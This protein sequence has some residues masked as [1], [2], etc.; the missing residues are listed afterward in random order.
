MKYQ[1]HLQTPIYRHSKTF[2]IVLFFLLSLKVISQNIAHQKN[3]YKI[4]LP[5]QLLIDSDRDGIIDINDLDDD[6]DGILD[7]VEE[8]QCRDS[9]SGEIIG[10]NL[11]LNPGFELGNI[12][13]TT[14]LLYF[15]DCT[16]NTNNQGPFYYA[17]TTEA[18]NCH[19]RWT[20]PP[21]EG[22]RFCAIDFPNNSSQNLWC[23]SLP[24]DQNKAYVFSA[25]FIN[26]LQDI[27]F[28]RTPIFGFTVTDDNSGTVTDFGQSD[29]QIDLSL[30]SNGWQEAGFT[31]TT[32]PEATTITICLKNITLGVGGNDAGIDNITLKTTYCDSDN[33]GIPNK[34]DLDSDNDGIYD[35]IEAGN[36][37]IIDTN[38]DG[39]ADGSV[40]AN[41]VPISTPNGTTPINSDN[42]ESPDYI[43]I[44]AD[45]D[46]IQDNIEAQ[47]TLSYIAPNEADTN[48]NGVDDAYDA[49]PIIPINT[50]GD[51]EPDYL[52]LN[53]DNDCLGDNV[54]AYDTNGDE[55]ADIIASGT[56][57]DNDGLDDA[58]DSVVL[59]VNTSTTN[60]TDNYETPNN[61]PNNQPQGGEVN[62]REYFNPS[63]PGTDGSLTLCNTN[64]PVDL[65]NSL[66]GTPDANG[67][68]TP[69]L[70]SGTGI[71]DPKADLDGT[72]TY[73]ISKN[74]CPDVSAQ[75]VVTINSAPNAGINSTIELCETDNT[76]NLIDKLGGTPTAGGI[77][78]PA[79]NSGTGIFNPSLDA[80]GEYT[81][82][83]IGTQP[84]NDDSANILVNVNPLPNAG[85]NSILNLCKTDDT[86]NLFNSLEGSPDTGGVW[87]PLLNST[88][89]IFDPALDASGVYTY[90]VTGTSPCSDASTEIT[91]NI[92]T[93]PNAGLN[94]FIS[95][96]NNDSAINLFNKI[97]GTPDIG[98]TW[99]PTL[100][101]GS[102]IFDPAI[103][104]P[105]IYSYT[106]NDAYCLPSTSQ[107]T[108]TINTASNAGNDGNLSICKTNEPVDLFTILNTTTI[109]GTWTPTLTSGSSIF[110]PNTD[111]AGTYTYTVNGTEP[112]DNDSAEITI[113]IYDELLLI[114]PENLRSCDTNNDNI[115]A[116]DLEEQT[117]IITADNVNYTV[118]YHSNQTDAD[119][120]QAP[121]TSPYT[122][123]TNP[124]TI[125]SRV[126]NSN[127][128]CYNSTINFNIE[129]HDEVI[130]NNDVYE[131][132]D[133][134]IE[135]D[136]NTTNN[137]DL[138]SRNEFILGPN[139]VSSNFNVS[140]YLTLDN[141]HNQT[142]PLAT[143]YT[144]TTNVQTIY[145]RVENTTTGCYKTSEVL[146]K[147]NPLP[148]FSLKEIYSFC[149]DNNGEIISPLP[150]INTGLNNNS[151]TFKWY[152]N[153]IL[154]SEETDSIL[155]PTQ[156]GIYSV[157]VTQNNTGC[158]YKTQTEVIEANSPTIEIQQTSITFVEQNNILAV[159]TNNGNPDSLY[160]FSLDNGPWVNNNNNN[161]YIF[162]N[163]IAGEHT[164]TVKDINGCGEASASIILLDF[165]PYFTPNGDGF[166]D[167]WNIIG[168]KNQPDAVIYIYNRYGKL[169]KKLNPNNIGWNGNYNNKIMPSDD[170]WFSLTYKDPNTNE[171]KQFKSHFSLK[172]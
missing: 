50:D 131:I 27:S 107:I 7:S 14:D 91:I 16:D 152:L 111:N 113:T 41:G 36:P 153:D 103:D 46:G 151:Y 104:Q 98:G 161:T 31:Y 84:C 140:Y 169:L 56:D 148:L 62:Y 51:N 40:D 52:D 65:F 33:D 149:K 159:A 77:W 125:Y 1:H 6:N 39:M 43:D 145:A 168:I 171:K 133:N 163:I 105:G 102:N 54:E 29:T 122:N 35:I 165:I 38:N 86:I 143:S 117:S 47:L 60:A 156:T 89:D 57:T 49:N 109:D 160:E 87:T 136:E 96:C 53:S 76:I 3:N 93:S 106:I 128:G 116:F 134:N 112:C 66:G 170:Y 139:Q 119:T 132:C 68:W 26:I 162:K 100:S 67:V 44:D 2:I 28:G 166:N 48:L 70:I 20:T 115:E 135:P 99:S 123:L 37:A 75:V 17:I 61:L 167:T 118:T 157:V 158:L 172:R 32:L 101:S 120:G 69:N 144:N 22:E 55:I 85:T 146:L 10:P 80:A 130:A 30:N 126:L 9:F 15:G 18:S 124:Q 4:N 164:I 59:E 42:A 23:Q 88:T 72:Y 24:V 127:T 154:I 74:T 110:N 45:N 114:N 129:L 83:V 21:Q 11:I 108:V 25:Y 155:T 73:T 71:L 12:N 137:F 63:N 58:Y 150:T 90:T 64:D 13:F 95:L 141:A 142:L 147:T 34:N 8:I 92:T 19:E 5:K 81:Y 97:D 121:L 82:T 94:S 78:T 138:E 79:L